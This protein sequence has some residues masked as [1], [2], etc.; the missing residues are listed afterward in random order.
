LI[1]LETLI[2][3]NMKFKLRICTIIF[4]M[5]LL[6]QNSFSQQNI[7]GWY[8][9]NGQP[10][11]MHL[12]WV[13][14]I[15]PT[16][17]FATG[18][19]GNFMKSTD[20]GNSWLINSQSGPTDNSSTTGGGT[21][22]NVAAHFFDANT[23]LV[24]GTSL[25]G[26]AI[27]RTT[28]GGQTFSRISLGSGSQYVFGFYF[29]NSTTG[30][31]CGDVNTGLYKTTDAGLSWS[32]LPIPL[33]TTNT[34]YCVY[35]FDENKIIVPGTGR[36]YLITY[37]GGST[38]TTILFPGSQFNTITDID[39]KD[40]NTGYVC[41]TGY[42]FAVTTDAGNSWTQKTG[43]PS[44]GG[45]RALSISGNTVFT[46]GDNDSLIYKTTD[47][48]NTWTGVN[49][50][51]GNPYQP[52]P[53]IMFG[54]DISGNNIAVVGQYG[55]V[56]ISTDGGT[57]WDNKNYCVSKSAISFS[58]IYAETPTG[59]ILAAGSP[60]IIL[61]STNGGTN[62]IERPSSSTQKT[63]N[64]QMLNSNTG[65]A[66][67]GNSGG[68]GAG[69][70]TKTTDGGFTWSNIPIP[71]PYSTRN[72]FDLD[73]INE[74]TGWII[75]GK[76]NSTGGGITCIKTTDGGLN[77][78]Q[79]PN[80]QGY[81]FLSVDIDMID[82][83]TGYFIAGTTTSV[84]KTSN[85]G[86]NWNR[87][88]SSPGTGTYNKLE[89]IAS[90]A[91]YLSGSSGQLFKSTN[92][93]STWT[94][95]A[96]PLASVALTAMD[97]IDEKNGMIGGSNGFIAKTTN[98]GLNW[99]SFN[100]GGSNIVNICM[101]NRDSVFAVSDFNG[102]W[103]VFRYFDQTPAPLSII[104][105][106]GIEG[107]WNGTSQVSDT[108]QITL[109]SANSPYNI[110]DYGRAVIYSQG[111]GTVTF[112]SA[113]AGNYYL[114][115]SHRNSLETW[116]ASVQTLSGGSNFY[117]FTTGVNKAFGNN[118]IL[119]YGK[120]CVYSGDVNQDDIIDASD[121]G[122]IDNDAFNFV[123]GYIPTDLTGDGTADGSDASIA[124]NNAWNFVSVIRP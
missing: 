90:D 9:M 23:G 92:G 59:K 121:I 49:M 124:D 24:G 16:T 10:Q 89:I 94:T 88:S 53:A 71:F 39:F 33:I 26:D 32:F 104:V 3:T 38:W 97:W 79:Q 77:W 45:Q 30:Y 6:S 117:D 105:K 58:A 64:I 67:S 29:L 43:P 93:G 122:L 82:E 69:L 123:S 40:A 31:A 54:M 55:V 95:I 68:A 70:L 8:W 14:Y 102:N 103:Q 84:F 12:N 66:V 4:L 86:N 111:S 118:M 61:Y 5:G 20:G 28:N 57:T 37:D 75:G 19:N 119:L 18:F 91:I 115:F 80:D 11:S 81:S 85:G 52:D 25:I 108:I 46:A 22:N 17:L 60:G 35:A 41:G 7:N 13:K 109:R 62:W 107:F 73:F 34:Y 116:S 101:R 112:N 36:K 42:Y 2:N 56:D 114:Q 76:P 65:Y 15:N 113:P 100:T 63:N 74:N 96:T 21:R 99:E 48:G 87:L 98:G 83:N 78:V 47:D 1:I 50:S 106:V 72:A 120:A 110:V 44:A 27:G 51:D